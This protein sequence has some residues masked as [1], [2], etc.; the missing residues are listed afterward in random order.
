MTDN[1]PATYAG[2]CRGGKL[3]GKRLASTERIHRL[4]IV[5]GLAERDG[6]VVIVKTRM[7][8]YEFVNDQW[9]Y[10]DHAP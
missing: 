1:R 2:I 8:H 7:V 3:S 4:Q 6:P 10:R 9:L 5:D